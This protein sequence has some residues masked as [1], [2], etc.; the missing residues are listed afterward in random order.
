MTSPGSD[1]LDLWC[2]F[3]EAV[4]QLPAE[5]REVIGLA[6]WGNDCRSPERSA[7]SRHE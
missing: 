6:L 2:R 5:E 7:R 3:H 4:D 1:D